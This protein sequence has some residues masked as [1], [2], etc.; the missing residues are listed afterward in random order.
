MCLAVPVRLVSRD[1]DLGEV[2]VSGVRR[3]TDLR[4]LPDAAPGDLVLL[5]AGFAISRVDQEY[6][7]EYWS[8]RAAFHEHEME[9]GGHA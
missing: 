6:Y 2:E 9:P 7:N 5:H 3:R 4:L 8:L 1:G